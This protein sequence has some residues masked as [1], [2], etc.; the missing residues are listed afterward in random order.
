MVFVN[1]QVFWNVT[2]RSIGSY[3]RFERAKYFPIILPLGSP[4]MFKHS[5]LM[6]ER[7]WGVLFYQ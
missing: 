7:A 1:F 2:L 5:V 6:H 4:S 3:R